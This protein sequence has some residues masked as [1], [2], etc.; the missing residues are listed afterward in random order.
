MS[1]NGQ[2]ERHFNAKA[3]QL[4]SGFRGSMRPQPLCLFCISLGK[5]LRAIVRF[6]KVVLI[7]KKEKVRNCCSVEIRNMRP[8]SFFKPVYPG[9]NLLCLLDKGRGPRTRYPKGTGPALS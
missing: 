6:R 5:K 1:I 7:Y 9:E 4:V 3:L 8:K 2:Q